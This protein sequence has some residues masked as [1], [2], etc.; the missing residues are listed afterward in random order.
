MGL[1]C[2]SLITVVAFFSFAAA[3][4][5][6]STST[7]EIQR[8]YPQ[9]ANGQ[10]WI[11]NIFGNVRVTAWDQPDVKVV[12]L[13][14][15]DTSANLASAE[16]VVQNQSDGLCIA[17][18]YAGS[19]H[20]FKE[21]F[22]LASDPCRDSQNLHGDRADLATVDYTISLPRNS[23]VTILNS[24]GDVEVQGT[25]GKLYVDIDKGR[26]TARDV[27]GECTLAGSYKGVN[28]T[29]TALPRD[30][31]IFS[32]V[33][34]LVVYVAPDLSARIRAHSNRGEVRNDFGWEQRPHQDLQASMGS[35]KVSLEVTSV[36]GRVEIRRLQP[37][38][39][40]P[41]TKKKLSTAT[42]KKAH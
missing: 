7:D 2:R 24:E 31:S 9:P 42:R 39:P 30:T 19:R 12:S 15:A 3:A 28:V 32:Y 5:A 1:L 29:L 40:E 11:R 6:Q 18:W 37:P 13:K 21:W 33:G 20:S 22:G 10:I 27:S 26:L 16:V 8:T 23:Q 4:G 35:G 25:A 36:D 38:Q 17:S 41:A 34:P 14:R